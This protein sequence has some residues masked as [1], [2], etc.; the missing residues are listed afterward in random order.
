MTG[1]YVYV[2]SDDHKGYCLNAA[3][4]SKVWEYTT[5][6]WVQS[7]PAVSGGNAYI[8][9]NDNKIYCHNSATGD[10]GEWPMFRYN[11]ERTGAK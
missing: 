4:G 1:G 5:G 9:S 3:D 6:V 2:G 7:S 10:T 8:G 11:N